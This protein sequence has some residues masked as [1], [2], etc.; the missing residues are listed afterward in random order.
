MTHAQ[1][2]LLSALALILGAYILSAHLTAALIQAVNGV[3]CDA[4]FLSAVCTY[5]DDSAVVGQGPFWLSVFL[6]VAG[7]ASLRFRKSS[8]FPFLTMMTVLCGAALL[9]DG[10]FQRPIL[11]SPKIVND[12][13]NILGA[14]VAASFV[15]VVVLVRDTHYSLGRLGLA[16]VLSF[17][18]KTL[19]SVAY[20]SLSSALFG[21]TELFLLY[22]I[23]SFGSFTVHLMTVCGFIDSLDQVETSEVVA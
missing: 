6:C 23:Y 20:V 4:R 12:T 11:H 18:V 17:A 22:V 21:V 3:P 10:V 8:I 16:V 9:W 14:V 15:M 2:R 1:A 19:S 7:L 13:L 5:P